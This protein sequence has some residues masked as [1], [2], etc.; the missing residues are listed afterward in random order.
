VIP[1]LR[2]YPIAID[3]SL[4]LSISIIFIIFPLII[5]FSLWRYRTIKRLMENQAV[6]RNGT[7]TGSFLL[8]QFKC[9][10]RNLPVTVT[11]VPGNRYRHAKTEVNI[12]LFKPVPGM[13]SIAPESLTSRFGRKL[14]I[15]EIHL[16]FDEFDREFL[17]RSE[18]EPF[19]RN[20]LSSALQTKLLEM[21]YEKPAV[22]IQGTWLT[23][24]IP[25]ILKTE[26]AYDQLFDLAFAFVDRISDL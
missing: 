18:N 21:K 13:V 24:T 9:S 26:E 10:Y 8:P 11:S 25:K 1:E 16:G 6:K 4:V 22:S 12:T 20:L 3:W 14:G 5:A 23:V 15:T 19:V 2:W 17:L 7:V